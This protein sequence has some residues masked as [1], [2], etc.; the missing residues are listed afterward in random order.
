MFK[1]ETQ[2]RS[3]SRYY[4]I[5]NDGAAYDEYLAYIN[6][7]F[8]TNGINKNS[9]IL[10]LACGTGEVT[11]RLHKEGYKVIALDFSPDMLSEASFKCSEV[12]N[13]EIFFTC[14]DM[15]NYRL[16]SQADSCVCL[17][18][19]LNY[20]LTKKDLN[21]AF[22]STSDALKDGGLFIFDVST[23]ERYESHYNQ[24]T[25]IFDYPELFC[26]WENAYDSEKQ[27][28]DFYLT[29]FIKN[30][31]QRDNYSRVDEHQRQKYFSEKTIRSLLDKNG[32]DV[33]SV[34]TDKDIFSSARENDIPHKMIFT[35]RKRIVENNLT[36]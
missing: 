19:S 21:A 3:I 9:R 30:A 4:D 26:A 22:Q 8:A 29:L 31:G 5:L 27:I 20:L 2:Y 14:Q 36:D 25:F 15:R 24:N 1:T 11:L 32:F 34:C 33:I 28:C 17:Y 23:S 35:A 13:S 16:Y 10:D 6:T 7:V 18:D 12:S